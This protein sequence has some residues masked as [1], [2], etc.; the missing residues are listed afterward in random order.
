[1]IDQFE[2]ETVIDFIDESLKVGFFRSGDCYIS[3]MSSAFYLRSTPESY[4]AVIVALYRWEC[5]YVNADHHFRLISCPVV[6]RQVAVDT[7][8]QLAS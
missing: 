5:F 2:G 6:Y 4:R 8:T 1:M 7:C 3:V